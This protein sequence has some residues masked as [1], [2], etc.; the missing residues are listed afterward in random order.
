MGGVGGL[1]CRVSART[2]PLIL[3]LKVQY[4]RARGGGMCHDVAGQ[5]M[6][7]ASHVTTLHGFTTKNSHVLM[8][9]QTAVICQH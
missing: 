6:H 9:T 2:R 4:S 5:G 7:H 1:T 8:A 3:P